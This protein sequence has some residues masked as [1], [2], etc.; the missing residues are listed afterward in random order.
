MAKRS[1]AMRRENTPALGFAEVGQAARRVSR[2]YGRREVVS[3]RAATTRQGCSPVG[4]SSSARNG[5]CAGGR[6]GGGSTRRGRSDRRFDA[7]Y[8]AD[9]RRAPPLVAL[10]CRPTTRS[11]ADGV[12]RVSARPRSSPQFDHIAVVDVPRTAERDNPR[13]R[14]PQESTTR[15]RAAGRRLQVLPKRERHTSHKRKRV[16]GSC[17]V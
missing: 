4:G 2:D 8:L 9:V 16:V 15:T 5:L 7:A 14:A 12:R 6:R 1:A 3:R 17:Y 11:V 13:R 10:R